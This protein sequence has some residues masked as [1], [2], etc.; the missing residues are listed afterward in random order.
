MHEASAVSALHLAWLSVCSL[1]AR[2]ACG[3]IL[4]YGQ[5]VQC[6]RGSNVQ[7]AFPQQFNHS[8][9]ASGSSPDAGPNQHMTIGGSHVSYAIL[10]ITRFSSA[11]P[12]S[13]VWPSMR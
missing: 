8:G 1:E 6:A 12:V 2:S 9:P 5:N 7:C 10:Q 13:Y 4:K 11:A 3:G